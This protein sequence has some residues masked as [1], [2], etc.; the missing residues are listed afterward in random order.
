MTLRLTSLS[1]PAQK[2][3]LEIAQA[4]AK[5]LSDELSRERRECTELRARMQEGKCRTDTPVAAKP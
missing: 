4:T 3:N 1:C 2:E 5:R